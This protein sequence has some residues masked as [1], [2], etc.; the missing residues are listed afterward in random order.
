MLLDL[1]HKLSMCHTLSQHSFYLKWCALSEAGHPAHERGV[2][3]VTC[4]VVHTMNIIV[5]LCKLALSNTCTDVAVPVPIA[6]TLT[7]SRK[8][9]R[10]S[11]A[12]VARS[13]M[14]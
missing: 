6:T 10:I 8:C 3:I 12:V 11:V 4:V 5:P 2:T 1:R 7:Q 13:L 9:V 14:L